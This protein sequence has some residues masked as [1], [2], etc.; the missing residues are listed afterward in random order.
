MRVYLLIFFTGLL[1]ASCTKTELETVTDN[2]APPDR[3]IEN[4]TIEN[5]VTRS[6]ILALG[7]E[8]SS[9]EFSNATSLLISAGL[10]STSRAQFLVSVFSNSAYLPQVYAQNKIDLLNNADTADFTAWINIF[11]FLLSDSSNVALFPYLEYEIA[12][13]VKL[14]SAFDDF[15]SGSIDLAELQRRMCSNNIYD[16]INMGSANFVISSFQHLLNRNPTIAEQNSGVSMVDGS[17]AVLF[18]EAGSSKEDYLNIITGTNNY[19]EAQVVFLYQ[20][21][22]N[23]APTNQEMSAGTLKYSSTNDYTIVQKDILSTNEF[24]GIQ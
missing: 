10:D 17:N 16:E 12:R 6:Y 14:Q 21:Y 13:L 19:Y 2:V 24:I 1:F 3:T 7:R 4:V 9:S 5:Y 20:K 11:G 8:P 18:L 23:R 15:I 22:L